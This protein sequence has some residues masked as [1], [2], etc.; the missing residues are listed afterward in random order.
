M[1]NLLKRAAAVLTAVVLM[2]AAA[3]RKKI[4]EAQAKA[5]TAPGEWI[6][7]DAMYAG[8]INTV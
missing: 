6:S 7:A 3:A 2:C 8:L 1:K 4:P 5:E